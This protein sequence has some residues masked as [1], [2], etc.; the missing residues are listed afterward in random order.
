MYDINVKKSGLGLVSPRV[1][2]YFIRNMKRI[3]E[4]SQK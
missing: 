1:S 4:E 2:L 3:F